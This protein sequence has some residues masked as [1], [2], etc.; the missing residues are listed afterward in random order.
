MNKKQP[1]EEITVYASS[2]DRGH[3]SVLVDKP[4]LEGGSEWV[5]A[6]TLEP[7]NDKRPCKTC[8]LAPI[9]GMDGCLGKLPG[10]SNACCGHGWNEPYVQFE[11]GVILRGFKIEQPK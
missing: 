2:R 9:N 11:N 5:Y 4:L 7:V 6:D 3:L 1:G 10:V 8:G